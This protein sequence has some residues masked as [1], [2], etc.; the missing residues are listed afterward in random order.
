MW[1]FI[2]K[3]GREDIFK[4]VTGNESLYEISDDDGVRVVN[5]ATPKNLVV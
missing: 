2:A 3:V 4:P 1:N 5:F